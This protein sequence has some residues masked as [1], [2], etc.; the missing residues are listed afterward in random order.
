MICRYCK[1]AGHS[2]EQCIKRKYA[3]QNKDKQNTTSQFQNQNQQGNQERPGQ[4]AR[5]AGK[6]QAAIIQLGESLPAPLS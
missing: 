3:N 2:I 6:L 5:P 1:N 4:G